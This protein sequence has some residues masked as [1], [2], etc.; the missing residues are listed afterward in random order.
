MDEKLVIKGYEY[1]KEVYAGRGVDV[2]KAIEAMKGVPISMNC[3]QADDVLGFDGDDTLSGG[4][5][6]TGNYPGRART[7]D[8]L[9]ADADKAMSMIPGEKKFN[10]HA[11]Y[12]NLNGRKIERS[13][14]TADLFS[15][16]MD[17]AKERGMGLDFNPTYFSHP[18][19]KDGFTLASP[20]KAV[21]DYWIEHGKRCREIGE[22]FY[23]TLGKECVINYW[24]P[25][26]YKDNPIDMAG[27]RARMVESLDAIFAGGNIEGVKEAVES[28]VFG[29]GV[30]SY[31]VGS[32][33]LMMGYA[34]TRNKLYCLDAGHFHPT[35]VISNKISSIMQY[36]PE[37]LL[38]VSRPVRWDSD[39]VVTMDD[40]LMAIMQQVV[41]NGYTQRVKI[42]LDFFDASINRL[43]AW[44]IG[45]RNARKALLRANLE[46]T[47]ELK[48]LELDADFTARLALTEEDKTL[49]F[50][51][52]WDYYC[53][54]EG[55][56]VGE[57]W[58]KE[59]RD[60]EK[61]V[62]SARG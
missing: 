56:P 20:D 11:S 34:I 12:A 38:H 19:V 42:A 24:M 10:L 23:K 29:L 5:A 31:T 6:T 16:W 33:E 58:L 47:A 40:E 62:M 27:P 57:D 22:A 8:E 15:E 37:L 4:I 26:G 2:D 13:E 39:H 9:R 49:P 45:T 53:L 55:V 25:D 48:K 51:A 60:Y 52:I 61:N 14:Y 32:H 36:M 28:K 18:M 43:A 21:R 54:K 7:A 3:W 35:E 17:W 30:E 46:N 59:V 50:G 1:A 44:I 41:R